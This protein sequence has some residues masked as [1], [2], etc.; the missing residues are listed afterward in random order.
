MALADFGTHL[1]ANDAKDS[2]PTPT[3][4][5]VPIMDTNCMAYIETQLHRIS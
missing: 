4:Y 2:E 1:H 5:Q 3:T